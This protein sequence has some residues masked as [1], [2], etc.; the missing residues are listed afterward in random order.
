MP[1]LTGLDDGRG[2]Y[3]RGT[4]RPHG[5]PEGR[6][7]TNV[8]FTHSATCEEDGPCAGDCPVHELDRQTAGTR[9]SKPSKTGSAGAD[10]DGVYGGGKGLP[11]DY[12]PISR[13]DD[14][15]AS[16]FYPTFRYEPKASASERPRL[17]DGTAWP[18]VKPLGLMRWLVRLITP[19]GGV[20]LD[21][22]GG[23]GTTAEACLAEG[24]ECVLI[25]QDPT[26]VELIKARLSKAIQPALK[27]DIEGAARA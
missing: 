6:W 2:V 1:E 10:R 18:T 15:G 5:N 27:L 9:A 25:E 3:G 23:T 20:V 11:R 26:A 19:P 12:T 8:V 21:P 24:F 14:G 16:R 4:R 22:F 13:A 7:P 17:P